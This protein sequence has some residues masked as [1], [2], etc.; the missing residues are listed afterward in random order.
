MLLVGIVVPLAVLA[1]EHGTANGTV[2]TAG[3]DRL[4]LQTNE[5]G[6][7]SLEVGKVKHEEEWVPNADQVALLKTLKQGDKVRVAWGQDHTGHYFIRE[8]AKAG[9]G[10]G[11]QEQ[12][13]AGRVQGRVITTGEDR[14]VIEKHEGGQMTLEAGWV[15]KEGQW[16]RNEDHLRVIKSLKQGDQMVAHWRLGDGQHFIIQEIAP[17]GPDGKPLP[18]EEADATARMSRELHAMREEMTAMRRE[19]AELKALVQQLVEASKK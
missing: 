15:Q 10:E 6:Q 3:E 11:S 12:Q 18:P 7:M 5:G 4:V 14:V 16:V 8:I 19:I 2:V 9:E 13:T 1:Q 17:V